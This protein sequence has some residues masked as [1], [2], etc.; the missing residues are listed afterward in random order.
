M[1]GGLN[2]L[3]VGGH[4]LKSVLAQPKRVALLAYLAAA[5]PKRLHRRDSLVALFWPELDQEHARAALRQALHGLRHALGEGVLVSRGDEDIGLDHEQIRCDV[6]EFERAAEAGRLADALDLYRGDLLE[7]FFIRGAPAF[8]QWLEDERVR[9]K[10]MALRSATLLAERGGLAESVQWGRRALRI[11]PLDEPTLRRLMQ[12]LDRLGDRAGALEAYETFAKRLT[13][14]LETDPAPETRALAG[15]VRE[16]VATLSS[17]A[18]ELP[19]LETAAELPEAASV[20]HLRRRWL[21]VAAALLGLAVV[22]AAVSLRSREPA[23]LNAKRVLVVPFANRTDDSTLDP[24]GNLAADWIT[25]G[26]ALTGRVEIADPGTMVL[27]GTTGSANRPRQAGHEAAAVRALSLASGSGLAVWGS[28]YRRGDSIEFDAQITDEVRGRILH[29]LEPVLGRPQEPRPALTIL[30]ERIMAVLAEAL[31]SR[32]GALASAAGQPPRYDAYLAFSAGVEI[33]Y[34]GRRARDALPYFQRAAALDSTYAL[35]LIWAAWA[36][37]GTALD[38]CDSTAVI[39]GRL[40]G[41]RL[42][43][44]EQ[45]QIDRVM[46]RCRGDLPAA[47]A[48][49]RA[50][51]EALPRSELMWEQLARDALDFDRPREAVTILERLHPDSGALDGRAGYYNWLTNA[52]HLLGQHDREL[53]AA[54]R[55]RRRFPRNLATLR[56]ELLALAALGRAREVSQRFDE[57]NALPPDP[58]RLPAPVMREIALDL[59]AHGDSAAARMALGRTLAWHASRPAAEQATESSRFERAQTHY[60]AGH[61]DSAHAIAAELARAYPQNEQYAGLLGVL[62]AQ[63][64]DRAEAT[65]VDRLLVALERPLGRGQAT[66]W[67][68]CIAALLGERDTAVDLLARA[69]DAGYVYQVRFLNAHV[70][71]SF[72]A[73]RTYPRFRELLRPK[74]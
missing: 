23:P 38:Q 41:M 5:T 35:P 18:T 17:N 33:F 45:M 31:D 40:A 48:L 4:E 55:A 8:E 49:G 29:P 34:G 64:G 28:M 10:V 50:L 74:G 26:L 32:L 21:G 70:E 36:H 20:P 67:R 63:R 69:L 9:L 65:R 62:A 43:G 53:E 60:A 11:A 3:G 66:Y 6:V 54:Q 56:M 68:A 15:A 59:A 2:L 1:L 46:A 73:L 57:I 37:G 12:T 47:Y 51:T 42:T 61:A 72:A 71:P 39:A 58:I 30:R 52:Y 44:L 19:P 25:R 22:V 7:G 27:G 16:R 14:E 13:A 24:L